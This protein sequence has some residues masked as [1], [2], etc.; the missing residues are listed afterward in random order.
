MPQQ[1]ILLRVPRRQG[2]DL[3]HVLT[4]GRALRSAKRS[5]GRIRVRLDPLDVG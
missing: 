5:A 1:R 2:E 3:A 4:V